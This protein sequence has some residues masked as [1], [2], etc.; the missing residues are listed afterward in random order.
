MSSEL[1]Q[2]P[3]YLKDIAKKFRRLV[4]CALHEKECEQ[5]IDETIFE[6]V[7]M[8]TF[9]EAKKLYEKEIPET[10]NIILK[11]AG[12][13]CDIYFKKDDV[14]GPEYIANC[15]TRDGKKIALGID[16][17]YDPEVGIVRIVFARA[18]SGAHYPESVLVYYKQV[19]SAP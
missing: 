15:W 11:E 8:T 19:P 9:E 17:E 2:V 14:P 16:V 13:N 6:D 7:E 18:Y 10:L 4:T 12:L 1:V 3:E 5:M